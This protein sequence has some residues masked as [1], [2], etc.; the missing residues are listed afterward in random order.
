VVDFV[1]ACFSVEYL[2]KKPK[3]F[4]AENNIVKTG[5]EKTS[6]FGKIRRKFGLSEEAG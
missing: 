3:A 6:L 4:H 5:S 1:N 2:D